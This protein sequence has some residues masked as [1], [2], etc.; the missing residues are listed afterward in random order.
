MIIVFRY[1]QK[2]VSVLVKTPKRTADRSGVFSGSKCC[3]GVI[4]YLEEDLKI[5]PEV[6]RDQVVC[7]IIV[8]QRIQKIVL[9]G[10]RSV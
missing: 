2:T 10:I 8:R 4:L 1:A 3:F 6:I 5:V 7:V 9:C